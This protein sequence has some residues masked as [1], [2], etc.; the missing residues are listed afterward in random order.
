MPSTLPITLAAAQLPH[1]QPAVMSA[2]AARFLN[3]LP[4][5]GPHQAPSGNTTG[6]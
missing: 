4:G 5:H 2:L 6:D 3:Q 1:S